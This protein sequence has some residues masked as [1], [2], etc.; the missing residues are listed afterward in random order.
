MDLVK[1]EPEEVRGGD[2]PV[3]V[4]DLYMDIVKEDTEVSPPKDSVEEMTI[5]LK[6]ELPC[7]DD[8]LD[9]DDHDADDQEEDENSQDDISYK[10]IGPPKVCSKCNKSWQP[11]LV[12]HKCHVNNDLPYKCS[13]CPEK[14]KF[15]RKLKEHEKSH[16]DS[17]N[18]KIC[19]ECGSVC[20]N[21]YFLMKHMR[22]H[23]HDKS[24]CINFKCNYCGDKLFK[25]KSQLESHMRLEHQ[26]SVC[27]AIFDS[28][29]KVKLHEKCHLKRNISPTEDID[30]ERSAIKKAA[31]IR[32]NRR[33]IT[34]H[35]SKNTSKSSAVSSTSLV[36]PQLKASQQTQASSSSLISCTPCRVKLVNVSTTNKSAM[37]VNRL[38]SAVKAIVIQNRAMRSVGRDYN[39]DKSKL[40]RYIS[41]LNEANLDPSTATDEELAEFLAMISGKTGG[42]TI[43]SAEQEKVLMTYLIKAG[44]IY[45]G[46]SRN[47]LRTMSYE[48]A[49]KLGVVYPA[50]WDVNQIASYDWYYGFI[51]RHPNLILRTPEQISANREKASLQQVQVL[52][53]LIS[54]LFSISNYLSHIVFGMSTK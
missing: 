31:I 46:L 10:M 30:G 23:K 6:S 4:V 13:I 17:W 53:L 25:R 51:H 54:V 2:S 18:F 27:R 36:E 20:K 41:K 43:L 19:V 29:D 14:F 48:F 28:K 33:I 5:E 52:S 47:E 8:D 32:T 44:E 21:V 11:E 26:C 37:D 40:S 45:Y 24:K 15:K 35:N 49:K 50:A 7:E 39:I 34:Q 22:Q 9:G 12:Q 38:V 1:T 3:Y 16:L 42:K